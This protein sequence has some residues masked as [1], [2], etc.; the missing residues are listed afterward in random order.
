MQVP[1]QI[2]FQYME[3]SAAIED[4]VRER[5]HK[6]QRFAEHVTCCRVTV[7]AP[8]KHQDKTGLYRVSIDITLPDE[9]TGAPSHAEQQHTHENVEVAIREAF[10]AARRQLEDYA[11]QRR[12]YIKMQDSKPHSHIA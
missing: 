9:V 2:K 11:R 3:P 5:C 1:L 6:L 8:H 12:A 4:R 10:E 7:D